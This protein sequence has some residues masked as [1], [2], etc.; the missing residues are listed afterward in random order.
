VP[1]LRPSCRPARPSDTGARR[2]EMAGLKLTD[3]DLDLDVLLVLGKDR[4]E[5]TCR[6]AA[7]RA[8][9][10]IATCAPV[11]ATRTPRRPP[12]RRTACSPADRL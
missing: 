11:P 3:V 1:T 10:W 9:R 6:S 2:D 5:R 8:R 12:V 7:R 4:R